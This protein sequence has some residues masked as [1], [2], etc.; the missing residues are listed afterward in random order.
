MPGALALFRSMRSDGFMLNRRSF[1]LSLT[2][3]LPAAFGQQRASGGESLVYFG[4]YTR[5]KSKGIYVSRFTPSDGKLS[6]PELA[7]ESVNPSFVALHPKGQFL[8]AVGETNTFQDQKTGSV[9]AFSIDR[10]TGQ[11]KLLNQLSS[12]G[13]GPCHLAVDRTGKNLLVA[14]YGGGSVAC[15]PLKPDGSMAESSAFIQHTGS[16]PNRSRQQGPHAHQVVLSPDNRFAFVPD[17]GLDSVMI[18][19]FDPAKGS[20]TPHDPPFAKTA[21][22]SGPRHMAFHPKGRFAYVICEINNTVTVLAYNAGKGVFTELQTATTLPKD[23]TGSSSTAEIEVHP[24][25]RFLYGS[26]RGH[27]SIAV[28]SLDAAKG[29]MTYLENV[30]TQGNTPRCFAIDPSGSFL[31]AVHERSENAV[32]FKIDPKTGALTPTGQTLEVGTPVSLQFLSR[33]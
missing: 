8:Y 26:N 16:G 11:L 31:I 3:A 25:G 28:Y 1:C 2:A 22:G 15:F 19:R 29:T 32:V 10:A 5:N 23:F 12:R 27:N 33:K 20:L 9:A 13:G 7:A 18:Y 14:N 21:P 24:N 4:T 6:P 30:P 17:L